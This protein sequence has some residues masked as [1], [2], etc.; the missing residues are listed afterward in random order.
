MKDNR[1]TIRSTEWQIKGVRSVGR[2][3]RRWRDDIVGQQ[4]AVLTSKGQR[5]LEDSGGGLLP[6][7]ERLSICSII[8]W[9]VGAP[10]DVTTNL[11]HSSLSS[12]F[13]TVLLSPK[14]VHSQMLSSHRFL[15]LPLLLPPCTVPWRNVLS[16]PEDLVMCPYHC[17]L[18]CFTMV[19]SSL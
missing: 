8:L 16:R 17:S 14:P 18:R 10:H 12:A 19:K 5:K 7:L 2:P 1:W 3:K 4:G 9:T 11:R 15:C 6:A 13:L